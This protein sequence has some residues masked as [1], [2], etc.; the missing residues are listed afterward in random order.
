[1]PDREVVRYE[2]DGP[3]AVLTM[4]HEPYNLLGPV[5]LD[6]LLAALDRAVADGQRTAVI[7]SGL[8]N[9]CA[10]ADVALFTARVRGERTSF[11][12]ADTV[13]RLETCPIPVVASVHGVCLGGG[14]ELALTTDYIIAARSARIG[15]VEVTIG[16][17]PL[18][19]AIQRVTQR[20]GALRAKEMAM[21][22]RR[23]DPDTLCGWGLLNLVV[24]DD[25]LEK[26]TMA[27][28]HEL[29]NGPTVAHAATKDLVYIAVNDG[30][31]AADEAMVRVQ[32][33]MWSSHDLA[34]GLRSYSE[35]GHGLARF[36]GR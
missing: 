12:A 35:Q 26:S 29:A 28:A 2:T 18:L 36:E 34:E 13:R 5:L 3:V 6:P 24:D 27:V 20:A 17:H 1:M 4:V 16:M 15:S 30:V 25:V 10:G 23:Y 21:L 14:F 7:R 22:G 31:V 33:P 19:G 11:S 32:E 9:F 8:R